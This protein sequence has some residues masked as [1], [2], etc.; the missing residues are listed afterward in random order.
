MKRIVILSNHH[1]YTYNFRK[2]IIQALL[3]KNYIVTVILPYGE[4]V[5][6]L[7]EMGCEVIN[8]PLDRRGINPITDY[9]LFKQYYN[10]IKK[11]EPEA[12]LSYTIK[13]NIYGGLVCRMLKT[14]FF[15]NITGLGTAAENP[16]V[17]QKII[18]QLYK[19]SLKKAT[20]VFFQNQ[21][22]QQFFI[23]NK[24]AKSP[25]KHQ[26]LPGSGV[27][28]EEFPL[29]EYPSDETVKFVFISRIMK[30]KGI[31][32]YLEAAEYIKNKYPNTEFHI[33]GFCEEDYEELLQEY[34]DKGIIIY[35]GMV[36]N[37]G[38]IIK[39]TH[40][41]VHPTYYPEGMSNVLLESA[42]SGRPL[43]TTDRSG[44][45]E[46]INHGTNGYIIDKKNT[47]DLIKHIKLFLQNN[48]NEKKRMG[49]KSRLKVEN[50]FDRDIVV[51]RYKRNIQK[52]LKG[53]D[54]N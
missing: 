51:R 11:I 32:Q 2:E 5:K 15:P 9:K 16:G 35:H 30:E 6:N 48:Y 12:V 31:D 24:I 26:L 1:A 18:I 17:L 13:P 52:A 49:Y 46:I 53:I 25:V 50:E 27:N 43:I 42:A 36:N 22:N 10:L 19:V 47:K 38:E 44:C 39:H 8:L 54:Y 37:V 3:D 41:T 34:Q 21:E 29:L 20:C 45:R 4:K 28:L 14:P 40:C 23:D 33:C 7:K